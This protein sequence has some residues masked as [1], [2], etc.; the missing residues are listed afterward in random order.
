MTLVYLRQ[1]FQFGLELF[2]LCTK[3]RNGKTSVLVGSS[4][5][6]DEAG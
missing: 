3:S 1:L 5:S 4:N 6:D 2:E